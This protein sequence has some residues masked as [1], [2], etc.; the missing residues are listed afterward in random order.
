MSFAGRLAGFLVDFVVGD[1]S[2]LAAGI[3][4]ALAVS[5]AIAASGIPAWWFLPLAVVALL[6]ESIVRAARR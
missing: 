3:A 2:R 4:V 1:D 5:A 6:A